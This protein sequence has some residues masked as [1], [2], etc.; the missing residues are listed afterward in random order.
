[1]L[2]RVSEI[3]CVPGL[4]GPGF[5]LAVPVMTNVG[6]VSHKGIMSDL[7]GPDGCPMAIHASKLYG[8]V[9]ESTMTE[10]VRTAVGPI[11]S[12]GYPGTLAPLEVIGRARA[13]MGRSWQPW[14]NC[15]HLVHWAHGLP[16]RSPQMRTAGK[17]AAGLASAA[18]FV[19]FAA[20]HAGGVP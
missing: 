19:L 11:T 8:Y 2:A 17:R 12:E 3:Q 6:V 20:R 1:M 4:Y 16:K 14:Q 10:F 7:E 13:L 5:V 9:V 18:A 15:E